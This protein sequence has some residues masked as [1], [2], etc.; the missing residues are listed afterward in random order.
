MHVHK[1]EAHKR[2][3]HSLKNWVNFVWPVISLS[4]AEHLLLFATLVSLPSNLFCKS[5]DVLGIL[6]FLCR[7]GSFPLSQRIFSSSK[8]TCFLFELFFP[9]WLVD[10]LSTVSFLL[11]SRWTFPEL[12][13]IVGLPTDEFTP[14][15]MQ[16]EKRKELYNI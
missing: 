2:Q 7:G 14:S 8:S 16:D 15:V 4:L 3:I 10:F 1:S 6:T 11:L 13:P 12:V 5:F 9:A